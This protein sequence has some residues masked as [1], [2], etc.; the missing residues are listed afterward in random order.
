MMSDMPGFMTLTFPIFINFLLALQRAP[1]GVPAPVFSTSP[2]YVMG[3]IMNISNQMGALS[4]AGQPPTSATQFPQQQQQIDPQM[5]N[6]RRL[7]FL[8]TS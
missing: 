3:N 8:V 1:V 4:I 2:P 7:W 6:G 5:A